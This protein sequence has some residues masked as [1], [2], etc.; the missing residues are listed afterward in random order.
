MGPVLAHPCLLSLLTLTP[1]PRALRAPACGLHRPLR[2]ATTP[3]PPSPPLRKRRPLALLE[4]PL[5]VG[6]GRDPRHDALRDALHP[7]LLLPLRLCWGGCSGGGE[8]GDGRGLLLCL[9]RGRGGRERGGGGGGERVERAE[10]AG[11]LE[12]EVLL[13]GVEVGEDVGVLFRVL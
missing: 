2:R 1:T 4:P 3:T 7:D 5:R 8:G 11:R 10:E 12:V 9:L 13:R 6:R